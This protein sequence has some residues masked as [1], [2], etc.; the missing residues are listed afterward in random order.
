VALENRGIAMAATMPRIATTS[1]SSI[2]VKA[3]ERVR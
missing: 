2:S 3:L 1:T